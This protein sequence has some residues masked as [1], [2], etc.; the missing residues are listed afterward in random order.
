[1]GAV[2]GKHIRIMKPAGTGSEYYNYKGFY[3]IVLMGVVNGNYEFVY[4]N[5]GAEGKT[6][7]GGC[8][9]QCDFARA[10]QQERL[11]LPA[12]VHL[13]T[14]TTVPCHLVADNAFPMGKRM[15]K[16][17]PHRFLTQSEKV[18]NYRLS[19]ARRIVENVFGIIS[20]RFQVL[21]TEMRFRVDNCVRVVRAICILHNVLRKLSGQ[22]YM[23]PGSLDNEDVNYQ[24]IPGDWRNG[25]EM[26]RMRP[27]TA[28]NPLKIAKDTRQKL[29][30]HF[31]SDAGAVP[32]QYAMTETSVDRI[33]GGL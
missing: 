6:A 25:E 29:T 2:D 28:K 19:R 7:D 18:F 32:W 26:V 1:M 31:M 13:D 30:D 14:N 11:N 33:L 22:A 12:D 3:S 10:L 27:T 9:R 20:S 15:L 8:W 17:Y 24:V 23:P 16:P 21:K 4:A 5:V